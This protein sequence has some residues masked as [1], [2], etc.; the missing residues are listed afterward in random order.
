MNNQQRIYKIKAI[1]K[2]CFTTIETDGEYGKSAFEN[3]LRKECQTCGLKELAQLQPRIDWKW[4]M[5]V[6]IVVWK[7]KENLLLKI[8]IDVQIVGEMIYKC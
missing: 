4:A 7:K 2:N 1:C 8:L 3:L 6:E 5:F